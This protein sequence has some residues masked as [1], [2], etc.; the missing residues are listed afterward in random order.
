MAP[1]VVERCKTLLEI[2]EQ[3]ANTEESVEVHRLFGNLTMEIIIASAFGRII[4]IQRGESDELVEAAKAIFSGT[5]EGQQ[6]SIERLVF[7]T[8]NFPCI[9]PLLRYIASRYSS[10][11]AAYQTLCRLAL[12]L[13]KMRRE[14]QEGHDYKDLLQLMID[15]T[16]EDRSEQMRLSDNEILAQCFVFLTA[17]YDTTANSLT[18]TAYLLA[19]N[20]DI[21]EKLIDEIRDYTSEHPNE[22]PYDA[23]KNMVYLDMVIQES[24]RM[25]PAAP[26]TSRHCSEAVTIDGVSVP[27]DAQVD[28]P[29]WHIHH[30]AEYWPNPEKFDPERFT[31]HSL[32]VCLFFEREDLHM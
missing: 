22:S 13:I 24:L 15:A 1:L 10:S 7:V 28:I 18:Y 6:L 12:T 9:Q 11:A 25:Y 19:L 2:L 4:D 26:R 29:V 3:S 8:S 5:S 16:A 32:F 17:G 27:K 31:Y 14:S 30:N 20:P 21:Q 23:S